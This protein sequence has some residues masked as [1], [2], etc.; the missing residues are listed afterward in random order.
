MYLHRM[1]VSGLGQG[2]CKHRHIKMKR[3]DEVVEELSQRDLTR[4]GRGGHHHAMGS[5]PTCA[6][7]EKHEEDGGP[8]HGD[9]EPP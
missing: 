8:G 1:Q 7:K 4:A 9:T 6:V 5:V 2:T 3:R